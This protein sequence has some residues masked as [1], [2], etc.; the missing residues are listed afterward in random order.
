MSRSG[1][2]LTRALA[3]K[4]RGYLIRNYVNL[5][6]SAQRSG[7]IRD[8]V[9][10]IEAYHQNFAPSK[11][12][13]V[14]DGL[15]ERREVSKGADALKRVMRSLF[16]PD[17]KGDYATSTLGRVLEPVSALVA[18]ARRAETERFLLTSAD[19][20]LRTPDADINSFLN[21]LMK[22]ES[23]DSVLSRRDALKA[24]A[25]LL[26]DPIFP[27]LVSELTTFFEEDAVKPALKFLAEKIDD[28]SL[29]DTLLF[30]RR[31]LGFRA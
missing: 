12:A 8:G 27:D 14:S 18:P 20:I 25:E 5:L 26:R 3:S 7:L 29:Q 30:I 16:E 19:E 9:R 1:N 24:A 28:G 4:D 15:E 22:E 6:V 10:L 2:D 31:L 11:A 17:R 13:D 21:D 23:E